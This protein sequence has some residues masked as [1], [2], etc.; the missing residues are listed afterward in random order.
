MIG[1]DILPGE[2]AREIRLLTLD[3]DS[4]SKRARWWISSQEGKLNTATSAECG[5]NGM[6][7]I[8]NVPN[9]EQS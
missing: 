6:R 1:V 9:V 3:R 5:S 7:M 4:D 8:S 2:I